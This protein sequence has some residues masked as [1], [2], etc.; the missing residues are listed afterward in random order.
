MA[1]RYSPSG[2]LSSRLLRLE[3][4]LAARPVVLAPS[5]SVPGPG[6]PLGPWA[7]QYLAAYLTRPFSHFH[8]WLVGQLRALGLLRPFLIAA[9]QAPYPRP[10]KILRKRGSSRCLFSYGKVARSR[11]FPATR[12]LL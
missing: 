10:A 8:D 11:Q 6:L 5:A 2:R 4:G 9:G 12:C 7:R 1:L 3:R